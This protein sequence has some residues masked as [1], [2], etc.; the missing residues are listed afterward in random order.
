[1]WRKVFYLD[2]GTNDIYVLPYTRLY[3]IWTTT[4]FTKSHIENFGFCS[5]QSGISR[6]GTGWPFRETISNPKPVDPDSQ[7]ELAKI[8]YQQPRIL[9]EVPHVFIRWHFVV[10]DYFQGIDYRKSK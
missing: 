3:D 8:F 9:S 10:R 1:M 5:S 2:Y 6:S 7:L 4:S